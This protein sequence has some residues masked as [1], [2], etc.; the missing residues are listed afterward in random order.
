MKYPRSY[1]LK[2]SL[3]ATNDD[4][5]HTSHEQWKD[6][7]IVIHLKMDGENFNMYQ[8]HCHAR[9]LDTGP[10][11]SRNWARAFHSQI[12]GDIP[13]GWRVCAENLYAKHSIF[14][15]NLESYVLCFSIW[16]EKNYCLG[17][18][19][20]QDW[21]DLLGVPSVPVLY[22]GIF[23]EKILCDVEES[24]DFE[25][26]EGYVLRIRDKFHYND[27]RK[28]VGKYVRK[29][30]IASINHHWRFEKITPNQLK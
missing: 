2:N 22:E 30:H 5:I 27:F 9:S 4:R 7:E 14:Y 17:W 8:D 3:G 1:H 13:P 21:F 20:T 10:H 12:Q 23:S 24:L 19:E 6:R 28:Y 16:D 26:D 15:D 11:E 18:D 25:K 29:N